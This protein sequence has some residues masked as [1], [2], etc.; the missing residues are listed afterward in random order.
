[1]PSDHPTALPLSGFF[2]DRLL[3]PHGVVLLET[4]WQKN[5]IVDDCRRLLASFMHNAPPTVGIKGLQVGAGDDAWDVTPP[6]APVPG[7]TALVDAHPYLVPSGSL[8]ITFLDATST[9]TATPTN[10]IQI[11]AT[12]APGVPSWPDGN[13]ATLT[14]REF[15]LVA[16]LGGADVLINYR[17]HTAIAKDPTSTL[18]RTIWLTF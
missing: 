13:H 4:D 17:I 5:V 12:L 14:L 7:T 3:D 8:A 11:V 2:R 6:A 1:M 16:S 18:V 9:P 15:G 10:R